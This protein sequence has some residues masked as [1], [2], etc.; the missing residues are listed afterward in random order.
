MSRF[1][2]SKFRH[3]EARLSRRESWISDI[4]AGTTLSCGNHI[5]SSCSLIAFNSDHPGV[6]GIVP[7]EDQGEERRH[8]TH[9]GCHSDLVTDLD[10]SPFDDFLLA[11]GSADRTMKLWRLPAPGQELPSGPGLVLGPED[12]RVEVLQFHPTVDGI[13]SWQPM[14]T[15]CRVLSGAGM[16]HW[17]SNSG[18]LTPE[19]SLRPCRVHRPTRTARTAGWHGQA[20]RNTLCPLDST[21]CVNMK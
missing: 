4:R 13:L 3:T 1:K 11:T 14:G 9:L 16:E 6:L 12:T 20:P 10:F 21:R 8:V 17:T 15:W 18:S 19:Q 2:V 7:L 5:K